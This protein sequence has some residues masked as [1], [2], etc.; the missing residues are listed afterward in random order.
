MADIYEQL[1][2]KLDT[3][4]KGY[5]RTEAGSEVNF[6]RKLFSE[7]DAAF[8]LKMKPG[9]HTAQQTAEYMGISIEEA[10]ENLDRMSSSHLIY[11][12]YMP[13][14]VEKF[15]RTVPFVHGLWELNTDKIELQDV[16]DR[17]HHFA[18]GFGE[19]LF[20]YR[21][22]IVRVVPTSADTVQDDAILRIDDARENVKQQNLI[23][24][25]D[26]VCRVSGKF[27]GACD[28]Q[29]STS[30][31]IMFGDMARFYYDE[32]V[33]NTRVITVKEALAI[34]D[35]NERRGYVTMVGHSMTYSAICN[36]PPCHCAILRAAKLSV[37]LGPKH[38]KQTFDR[39]GNYFCVYDA[40]KCT[41]CGI[42]TTRCPMSALSMAEG[43]VVAYER[44]LCIG[45]G[46]CVTQCPS[47]ALIL[48]RKPQ[49]ELNIPEDDGYD[50]FDRMA[51]EKAQ[52]D[53]ERLEIERRA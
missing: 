36:C 7:E 9:P 51:V 27:G 45:C 32:K 41:Q 43:N 28:C 50:Y 21:L 5:P 29:E 17:V 40:D 35:E 12:E 53:K 2:N 13:G 30:T 18:N 15:Y 47:K 24:A 52:V 20:D 48:Q 42:C 49:D 1:A 46:L 14:S 10:T 22:P 26:C 6:L 19:T 25:A 38:G 34:L 44:A 31:C 16:I 4:G 8:H 11:W 33:A 39:W 37:A 23:I 3:L